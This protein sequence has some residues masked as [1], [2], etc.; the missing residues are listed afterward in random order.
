MSRTTF[1]AIGAT[2]AALLV[3]GCSGFSRS[4]TSLSLPATSAAANPVQRENSRPGTPGWEIPANAGTVITGYASETS[5]TP[6]QSFQLHV[7]APPGS[8]YR[9][10]V[11]RLGW[12]QGIGG[13]LIAC[14]PGC[15]SSHA[16]IAQPPP[17]TPD[18]VTGLFRAPWR[19]TENV[20]IPSDAA[21]GYYEAKLEIVSG[22][23]A[24]AVGNVPLIVRQNPAAPATAVLVQVPVNT[25]EAYNPWGGKSLYQFNTSR[26]AL[27]VSFDRPFD[28]SEFH[29]MVT[30]LELPWVRFLERSGI[31]VSYQ[32]DID[33]DTTPGSLLHHRLVFSIGHDEYWTQQMRE[34][35]DQ[36][37]A[38]AVN[39]MFGSN[40]GEW[41]MRYAAGRRAIVEWRD[42]SL[43]SSLDPVR[44]PRLESGFF[45]S[46]GEPECR[47]M[48]VEHLWAAQRDLTSPPTAYTVVGPRSDPWLAAAGLA[49]GD[50]IPGVV[51]YEWDSYIPDCFAG[52]VVR[53]MTTSI[54]GSGGVTHSADMVR[55]TAPSGGRVFAMGTMELAWALDGQG[56]RSADPRVTALVTAALRDLT[57]SAR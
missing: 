17:T 50:V 48:G 7:A 19:V 9:V 33:T 23:H 1:L 15:R 3:S 46:F 29:D 20:V 47:L 42:S 18:S 37:L 10:F 4:G 56:G 39:L 36:A 14:V 11:Y 26:H 8:R 25:W 45:S 51:G 21:S 40:S 55:A 32:T 35:F 5:V 38:R 24:G 53:L 13:R 31:D 16:A 2:I 41:R 6:G 34:A 57:R 22:A 28:Q 44:D 12:Y 52:Q 27:E 43:D 54:P 30:R 49:P